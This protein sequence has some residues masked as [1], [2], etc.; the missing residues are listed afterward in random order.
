MTSLQPLGLLQ[1]SGVRSRSFGSHRTG[2]CTTPHR[3][4]PPRMRRRTGFHVLEGHVLE[5]EHL[6]RASQHRRRRLLAWIVVGKR[7]NAPGRRR[8]PTRDANVYLAC[9]WPILRVKLPSCKLRVR[10]A[11]RLAECAESIEQR[12]DIQGLVFGAGCRFTSMTHKVQWVSSYTILASLRQ[13]TRIVLHGPCD[14][15]HERC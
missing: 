12:P 5:R 10:Q 8:P 4:P 6:G 15:R 2:R 1:K 13:L 11:G 14:R 9:S 3:T 7:C